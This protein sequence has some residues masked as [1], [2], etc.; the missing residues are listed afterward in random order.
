MIDQQTETQDVIAQELDWHEVFSRPDHNVPVESG[1][2]AATDGA[3]KLYRAWAHSNM[4]AH[5]AVSAIYESCDQADLP[6]NDR[7]WIPMLHMQRDQLVA[8]A[9]RNRALMRPE[10]R[11]YEDMQHLCRDLHVEAVRIYNEWEKAEQIRKL[12]QEE[13]DRAMILARQFLLGLQLLTE[14]GTAKEKA[15]A[16]H[17]IKKQ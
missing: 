7:G 10:Q 11:S 1:I 3:K 6:A 13:N 14:Q 17:I 5:H 12:Q 2:E 4:C 9:A 8:E 15:A 16:S